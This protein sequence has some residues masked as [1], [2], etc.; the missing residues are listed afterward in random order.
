M[1]SQHLSAIQVVVPML[2]APL[3]VIFRSASAAWCIAMGVGIICML[4][5]IAIL[6]EINESGLIIYALGG[7]AAPWGIEYA[8]DGANAFVL[9]IISVIFVVTLMYSYVSVRRE[10]AED[11]QSWFYAALLLCF[12]GLCGITVSGD[13]FNVFVFLEVSSLSSY[14]LISFGTSRRCLSAA[15]RYL[16]LGTIAATFYLI[17]IGLLYAMT[18][19]LNMSDLATRLPEI[20]DHRS[21]YTAFGFIVVGL[22]IKMAM[23]PLHSWLPTAYAYAPSAVTAF[24]AGTATKAAVYVFSRI[25]FQIFPSDYFTDVT[26]THWIILGLGVAGALGA[27]L[28]ACYQTELKRLFA[29]SSISQVGYIVIGLGMAT[30]SGITAAFLHLFNHALIKTAIFMAIGALLF[31]TGSSRLASLQDAG[32]RMPWTM[33]AVL[34]GGLSLIGVPATTGFVSKWY[35]VTAALDHGYWWLAFITLIGSLITAAYVWK[36]VELAYFRV[37]RSAAVIRSEAPLALLIPTWLLIAANIYFGLNAQF[38]GA[39]AFAAARW[40]LGAVI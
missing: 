30:T 31:K 6:L 8:I 40:L 36:V 1:I 7:W 32:R 5:A 24:L 22:G 3:C 15:L 2:A 14:I 16:F 18:G 17:G 19:T 20:A 4:N 37:D 28:I 33:A 38:T 10:V 9:L 23:F 35:L 11:K 29:W 13:V 27:S 25:V 12:T 26:L 39:Q 21:I 34:I